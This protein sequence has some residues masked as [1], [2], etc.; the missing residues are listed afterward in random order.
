MPSDGCHDAQKIL[1]AAPKVA[2]KAVPFDM[3]RLAQEAGTVINA[4]LF[5]AMAG[6]GALPLSRA[7]CE[8]AIRG[9]GKAPKPACAGLRRALSM[10]CP[11]SPGRGPTTP[12]LSPGERAD[13][14]PPL[15][16]RGPG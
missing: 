8:H 10:R 11:L 15:P 13:H 5:G 4:V 7:A 9:A 12:P 6:S 3:S 16:G 2:Q 14:A 1:E